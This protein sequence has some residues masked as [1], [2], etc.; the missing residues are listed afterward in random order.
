M[1]RNLIPIEIIF[2]PNWWYQNYGVSF[3]R[4]FFFDPWQRVKYERTME[5]VL[6]ANFGQFGFGYN[7]EELLPVAGSRHVAGGFVIPA[8]LG[9]EVGFAP[10]YAPWVIPLNLTEEE[11]M[12][13]HVPDI[14]TTSPM[15]ELIGVMDVL[16]AEFGY[17]VGDF[18]CDGILNI[19]LDLRGQQLYLDFYDKPYL[20]KHLFGVIAQTIV[21]TAQYVK[22]RTGTNSIS[23]NRMITK[24]DPGL[25]LH[26]NCA[27]CQIS[28]SIYETFLLPLEKYLAKHLYPYGIHHCGANLHVYIDQYKQIPASFIDVG[29]GSDVAAVRN[30]FPKAFLNL[31]LSPVR[32]LQAK[33]EEIEQDIT[34]LLIEANCIENI[35]VCCINMDYGTPLQNLETFFDTVEYA[36]LHR[37]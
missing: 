30:S 13:L 12:I 6:Y 7:K 36:R 25:Y 18:N 37:I 9:C 1:N 24:V 32:M 2:N 16:Q 21:E 17:V 15:K 35:G 29:W 31:R 3:D 26:G 10:E 27:V 8:M 28:P 33:P 23:V 22:S 11:I 4:S 20:V 19:A 5:Q 34:K 14:H